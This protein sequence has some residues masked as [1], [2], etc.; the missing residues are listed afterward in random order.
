MMLRAWILSGGDSELAGARPE[1]NAPVL[2]CKEATIR[3][4][5]VQLFVAVI[6]PSSGY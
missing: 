1:W 2:G 4:S 3:R 6:G 5:S